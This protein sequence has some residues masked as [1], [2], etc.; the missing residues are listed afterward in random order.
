[1][2]KLLLIVVTI[3]GYI[4]TSWGADTT[5]TKTLTFS[6]MAE[7]YYS[8]DFSQ[9]TSNTRPSFVYS[10]NR[11]NEVNL[12]LAYTKAHYQSTFIRANLALA[13]GTYIAA[14]YADEPSVLKNIYEANIG[15]KLLPRHNL[16]IDAGIMPSHIGVESANSLNCSTLTRSI[17][18]DNSPYYESGASLNYT[19]PSSKW[20]MAVLLLNGWQQIQRTAGNSH[21]NTGTQLTY[22][23][24]P[25]L[26]I[27]YSTFAGKVHP[28][29]IA[30]LRIFHNLYTIFKLNSK[31]NIIAGI[32]YGNQQS[33]GYTHTWHSWLGAALIA[34]Y[35]TST[36]T[37][38]AA[39]AEYYQ[40]NNSTITQPL[41]LGYLHTR[42]YS[43][44]VDYTIG[45]NV[46]WR[47][48]AK[49]YHS[50]TPLFTTATGTASTT[51]YLATTS[52][53][54]QL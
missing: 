12:N 43:A 10:H 16:W 31:T 34:S 1:M 28:D 50:T 27:N 29:S 7:V 46:R 32:D 39:R 51:S 19:T 47:T 11:H 2:K 45:P 44:N 35:R 26:T 14:N 17:I 30:Q 25:V 37:T 48:E 4:S 20:Y 9:P 41:P 21:I 15:I 5:I 38:V 3:W 13:T 23:P 52:I 49:I 33:A 24:S 18:A 42:A 54:I 53:A 22:S 8:F 40:D 36:R 6:A